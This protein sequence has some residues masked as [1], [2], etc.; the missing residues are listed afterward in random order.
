MNFD[1]HDKYKDFSN[2]ELLKII[3]RPNEYQVSAVEAAT[4]ILSS[5]QISA[6]DIEQVENYFNKIDAETKRK[7]DKE[8][9]YK[10]NTVDFFEPIL[11]PTVQVKSEKWL[12]ILLLVIGLQYL[13]TLYLSIIDLIRFIKFV[14]DCKAYGF[15]SNAE[16]ISYWTCFSSRFDPLVFLQIFSLIYVPIVF[17]LLFKRRRWG[18]ILFFA[19]NLIGLVAGIGQ[20]HLFF[21]Y[22]QFHNGDTLSFFIQILIK[23]V[24]VFFL[25]RKSISDLFNVMIETKKKTVIITSVLII[26]F[27]LVMLLLV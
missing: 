19:D 16:T 22:Q 21:K 24:L 1:F 8:S 12:N 4:Q 23:V 26:L 18:W 11:N 20:L 14:I 25:W 10:Q 15:D 17:Y 6:T 2:I 9:S 3:R 27:I 13:W 7:T 5:R